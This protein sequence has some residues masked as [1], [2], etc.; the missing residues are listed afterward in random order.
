[1]KIESYGSQIF[2]KI[3]WLHLFK[4][5]WQYQVNRKAKAYKK[6]IVEFEIVPGLLRKFRLK[7]YKTKG[8]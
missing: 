4:L 5:G 8:Y 2:G 7:R 1:M 3:I 6:D